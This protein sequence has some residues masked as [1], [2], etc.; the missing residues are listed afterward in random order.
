MRFPRRHV[1]AIWLIATILCIPLLR[2][3]RRP[4]DRVNGPMPQSVYVWQRA[5]DAPLRAA[6]R[7]HAGTFTHVNRL[8]AEVDWAG[9]AT[10]VAIADLPAGELAPLPSLGLTLRLGALPGQTIGQPHDPR[11]PFLQTL[12]TRLIDDARRHGLRVTEVQIDFDAAESQLAGYGHWLRA[13]RDTIPADIRLT[14]TALPAWLDRRAGFT[15]LLG[16]CDGYVLQVHSLERPRGDGHDFQLYRVD[17]ARR[18]VERAARFGKPFLVSLPTYGYRLLAD[19]RTGVSRIAPAG[20]ADE[21]P[22][23][24]A[25]HSVQTSPADMLAL[26][27]GWTSDRPAALAGVI[28]FR[29][30]V[31]D[32][33]LNWS[34][35]T[36]A[37]VIDGR[38]P[39][40]A[41][42]LE[43][44]RDRTPLIELHLRNTGEDTFAGPV[45]VRLENIRPLLASDTVRP[46]RRTGDGTDCSAPFLR[47][48]PGHETTVAWLR[49]NT[50]PVDFHASLETP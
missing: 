18:S 24:T 41:L 26:L 1:V 38:L 39:A 13:L 33:E 20:L 50:P 32:D 3:F 12:T 6:L 2:T 46:F 35:P 19:T 45:S 36:L 15:T 8:A 16:A 37:A 29:L 28:W 43:I 9:Q 22:A 27:R 21:L 17:D 40:P 49:F 48:A 31:A 14:F 47:L 7:E 25:S 42:R 30:P 11:V 44:D 34:W 5:A 10:A 23:G 4:V